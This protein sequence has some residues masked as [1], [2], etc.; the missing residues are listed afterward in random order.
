MTYDTINDAVTMRPGGEGALLAGRYRIVRQLGQGGMGSVWLAE[1]TQLDGKQFAIKMLPSILV[2]NKRAY[3]QLKDEALVAMKLTHPN[4]VTL[5]AFEENNGNPFLVMDYIDGEPLDDCLEEWGTL[6]EGQ[7]AALLRPVASAL[8]YAHRQGVV[9]RDV[10]PGNIMVR[11]DGV[12]FVLDFG[13]AREIQETLTRVTGRLSSGTLLYMSPEQLNG[14]TPAPSQD[15]YSFAAMAYECMKGEPPFVRGAIEDQ[16]KNKQPTPLIGCIGRNGAN[17]IARSVMAGLAKNPKDRPTTCMAML[18]GQSSDA[19]GA[20]RSLGGLNFKKFLELPRPLLYA[21]SAVVGILA[22]AVVLS[23]AWPSAPQAPVVVRHEVTRQQVD[24]KKREAEAAL[25]ALSGVLTEK[26][27]RLECERIGESAK[28]EYAKEKWES[29]YRLYSQMGKMATD[30]LIRT[31]T[32]KGADAAKNEAIRAR[33]AAVAAEAAKYDNAGLTNAVVIVEDGD[34]A[35]SKGAYEAAIAKFN[36]ARKAFEAC[37][38]KAVAKIIEMAES[39]KKECE[40]ERDKAKDLGATELAPKQWQEAERLKSE[41]ESAFGKGDHSGAGEAFRRARGAYREAADGARKATLAALCLAANNAKDM[42]DKCIEE[43]SNT[44]AETYASNAFNLILADYA[45]GTNA[46]ACEA[47]VQA[48]EFFDKACKASVG[49]KQ[50]IADAKEKEQLIQET[51]RKKV[52]AEELIKKLRESHAEIYG[53]DAFSTILKQYDSGTN[54]LA[55]KAYPE[56]N[57]C[58][59]GISAAYE[60]CML[61]ISE[62]KEKAAAALLKDAAEEALSKVKSVKGDELDPVQWTTATNVLAVAL[63]EFEGREWTEAQRGFE[64]TKK[65]FDATLTVLPIAK[66]AFDA[67]E[68]AFKKR[69]EAEPV[70]E[71]RNTVDWASGNKHIAK[72]YKFLKQRDFRKAKSAYD[73]AAKSFCLAAQEGRAWA[74]KKA[75]LAAQNNVR[76]QIDIKSPSSTVLDT[77]NYKTRDTKTLTLPGGAT[78]EMIYVGPQEFDMGSNNGDSDEKPVHRVRLTKGYWL[79][80]CEVTQGQWQSVMN[81]TQDWLSN[82]AG[83]A[84]R[85]VG[86]DNP[87]YHVSWND[88]QEFLGKI[89]NSVRGQFGNFKASLPTEAQWECACR[90]GTTGDYAGNLSSMAWYGD[91]SGG[92]THPVGTKSANAWGF[93]DMHGNVWERCQDWY[94]DYPSGSV[95]DPSGHVSGSLSNRVDRGGCWFNGAGYCR[96]ANRGWSDPGLRSDCLGFRVALVPSP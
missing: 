91:N 23:L 10:K 43:L 65:L 47:Y 80:K 92:A 73:D 60:A 4:I 13:I 71:Q 9:H 95:V 52:T 88:C 94:G 14:E 50:E 8:D 63:G 54:A 70:S 19:R 5:R 33:D 38:K 76:Q 40:S 77:G 57:K 51:E 42:A 82:R 64:V 41:G 59:D 30:A 49:C 45:S 20:R 34:K 72:G 26:A 29:A 89:Q 12:P 55:S 62:E 16:I 3:R 78:M 74:S 35:Y 15:I 48:K 39:G 17:S 61:A 66:E 83:Y 28:D 1:D 18:R 37:A 93:H 7:T 24:D 21:V 67:R 44:G 69:K 90:A 81:Q 86:R 58:F 84:T 36:V 85:G 56:A 32:K 6:T 68:E 75:A 11:K 79:G 2:S 53:G 25:L 22:V 46:V 31:G 27:A 96:S 87:V